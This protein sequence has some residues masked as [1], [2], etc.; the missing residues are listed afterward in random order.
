ML[1]FLQP[2]REITLLTEWLS[3]NC[4]LYG[5][6]VPLGLVA[7]SFRSPDAK[8]VGSRLAWKLLLVS[9]GRLETGR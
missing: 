6:C 2:S 4:D 1:G 7:T 9:V 5:L 8:F 3:Q